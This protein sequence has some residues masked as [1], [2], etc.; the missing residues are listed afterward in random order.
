M[1]GAQLSNEHLQQFYRRL[2]RIE[3]ERTGNSSVARGQLPYARSR[4]LRRGSGVTGWLMR[5]FST[6]VA[7]FFVTKAALITGMGAEVY[8]ARYAEL[9]WHAGVERGM[10]LMLAPDP[11]ALRLGEA[12]RLA[13]LREGWASPPP[14]PAPLPQI[15]VAS[16]GPETPRPAG[17]L[18]QVGVPATQ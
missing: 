12:L 5:S 18:P 14:A 9:Q 2:E 3:A 16:A 15:G 6:L 1:S 7:V 4:R 17:R 10:V 11:V 13:G 8:A